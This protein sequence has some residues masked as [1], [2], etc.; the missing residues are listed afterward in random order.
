MNDGGFWSHAE[1]IEGNPA[2]AA[3]TGGK[4]MNR[5]FGPH[6]LQEGATVTPTIS[7]TGSNEIT[8]TTVIAAVERL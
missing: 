4:M 1:L 8:V 2:L 3:Q 7:V 6:Y 5:I